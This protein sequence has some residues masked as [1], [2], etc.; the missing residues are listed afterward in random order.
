MPDE[1][2]R[3]LDEL[4][5]SRRIVRVGSGDKTF[6]IHTDRL[7]ALAKSV[8]RTIT[9]EV[10]RHQPRRSLPKPTLLTA[11]RSISALNILECVLQHLIQKKLLIQIGGNLG[12]ADLQVQLTKQQRKALEEVLRQFSESGATPPTNKELADS[13]GRKLAEIDQLLNLSVEDG[14]IIRVA[15][16]LF[17]TPQTLDDLRV[18]C[19]E[20]IDAVGPATMAQLRD[21]WGVTRKFAVPLCEYFDTLRIT[22]RDGDN[23][24]A[25]EAIN[26]SLVHTAEQL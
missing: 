15:D 22:K 5:A 19:R 1:V 17:F 2:R 13:T 21:A 12:P 6:E 25:G 9:N 18:K 8:L 26:E 16:G 20:T 24:V 10:V 4:R 7:E 23:R 3:L 11:C 14:L